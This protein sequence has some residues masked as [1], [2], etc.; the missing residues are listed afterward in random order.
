MLA[1]LAAAP[2]AA[3]FISVGTYEAFW[4]A[5]LI[6]HGAPIHSFDAAVALGF[7][8]LILAV[9]VTGT[10]AVPGVI[11]L[12][13]KRWLTLGK[14]LAFGAVVGNMPFALIVAGVIVA[15]L[16]GV[17]TGD[18]AENWYGLSGAI[19]RVAMGVAAGAGG[20]ATFWL[21]SVCGTLAEDGRSTLPL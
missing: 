12:N 5:G 11:W 15:R 14:V 17:L 7:G 20:A 10:A 8:V 1:G 19:V 9:V 21:V 16:S 4:H 18:V 2:V 13:K 6:P 3:A